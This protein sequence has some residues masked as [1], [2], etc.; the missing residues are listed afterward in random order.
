MDK[1]VLSGL[2]VASLVCFRFAFKMAGKCAAT[3]C[4]FFFLVI[5]VLI[6][7]VVFLGFGWLFLF[8]H[9]SAGNTLTVYPASDLEPVIDPGSTVKCSVFTILGFQI[10]SLQFFIRA[11]TTREDQGF[12]LNGLAVY[13]NP[14]N[15]CQPL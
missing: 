11:T 12:I 1:S 14:S 9:L 7:V 3:S 10:P 13:S 8:D 4:C 15:A 2:L 6:F 5:I